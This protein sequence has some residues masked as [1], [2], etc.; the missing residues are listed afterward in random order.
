MYNKKHLK[1]IGQ[2]FNLKPAEV[3][4]MIE[5]YKAYIL[6]HL[7]NFNPELPL[8]EQ[9]TGFEIPGIGYSVVMKDYLTADAFK[10]GVIPDTKEFDALRN[11]Y[12]PERLSKIE[13]KYRMNV[14]YVRDIKE[15]GYLPVIEEA[16]EADRKEITKRKKDVTG[17]K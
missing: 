13:Q 17:T 1:E 9:Y 8:F 11:I 16:W 4:D 6:Y 2:K 7:K 15:K 12:T 5:I 14:K 3:K 10:C